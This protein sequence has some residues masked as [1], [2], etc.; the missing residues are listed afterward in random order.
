MS[1]YFWDDSTVVIMIKF[2]IY[3]LPH[4]PDFKRSTKQQNF[5]LV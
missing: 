3:S 2:I 4:N 1:F 5:R